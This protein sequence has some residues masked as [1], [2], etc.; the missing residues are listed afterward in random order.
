MSL[1]DRTNSTAPADLT[2]PGGPDL[3]PGGAGLPDTVPNDGNPVLS[4][5][6]D[7]AGNGYTAAP[8]DSGDSD[9]TADP[10]SDLGSNT[11]LHARP[12]LGGRASVSETAAPAPASAAPVDFAELDVPGADLG[13]DVVPFVVESTPAQVA[14]ARAFFAAAKTA[15]SP[16]QV[17]RARMQSRVFSVMQYR[18]HPE[19][20]EFMLTQE[21]LDEGLAA[22]GD[23]LHR[24]AYVWHPYDRLV[25]VDEG[26]GETVCCGIKGLHAHMVLWVAD[27]DGPRPTIRTVSDAFSIPSARVKPPKETA[28]Q[29][30]TEHKG[31]GAAEKAFFDLA[32]YLPHE[33]RG[34]NATPGIYQSDRHYLVDKLQEG[35]PGKYQYGRGRI[36]ANFDFGRE[37]D[38]HMAMRRNAAEGGGGAKLSKLFQAVGM[39][40]LTL[41]QVR[42]QEPAIYFAKGNLAH[43]Q[44]LRGDYLA[45]QDAPE[46][47]MNFYV[48]GEGGTGKD[49]LAKALARALAPDADKP[50]FKVGGENVSWEG[51]D[52]EPVVIWE[53]M[54]VGDMIRTAKSRGML[55]RILGPWREP[56]EKPIVN[57][58]GSKTQLLNRV[59]IVTGPEG[60][61]EFLRGLAGEYES[62]QGGV[63]VKHQAENL[64]QG[65]RRFPVII[66]VAEREF[67]IFVNSGVLNGTREYQSYERYEHMCQ[68]L[69]LL[70]RRCKAIKDAAERERVRGEIEARTVA[71]IVEQHDRIAAPD[72]EAIN[73]DDLFAEFAGVGQ[74]IQPSAEEIAAAEE[75]AKRDRELVEE[76]QRRRLA[77]LEEHNRELKLCTCAT[78]QSGVYARHGDECPALSEDERQRRAEAKQKALD[79]KVERLRANG[80]LLVAG[81]A[82]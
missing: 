69:E 39:G 4:V 38:A 27:A 61:E 68:D 74:P 13:D 22:L 58:K 2:S 79:A 82:L 14:E 43:F 62:M 8:T 76:Q 45:Y 35:M 72:L 7:F 71:P 25:E 34:K 24:W 65:F 10:S 6:D 67:S 47:V 17:K 30:G 11:A 40:S 15:E 5:W 52:G 59:N 42:D 49:L 80:G 73:G 28:E 29:E 1:T 77:E 70:A 64:G 26:T 56:D 12:S 18:A 46:S 75:T 33:S 50:Y 60:Y 32:E 44:K 31:R 78:P 9:T 53:D 36:V 3:A 57:I 51:Y 16:E 21:Q 20:G 19:T 63:R 54:R 37:L 81:G 41:K 48:F 55:F 66:P 23:R